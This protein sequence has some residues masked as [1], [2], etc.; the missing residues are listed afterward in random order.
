MQKRMSLFCTVKGNYVKGF[1]AEV[2]KAFLVLRNQIFK[3]WNAIH[4][5]T[6]L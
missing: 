5:G 1:E 2:D 4:K 3:P 6:T